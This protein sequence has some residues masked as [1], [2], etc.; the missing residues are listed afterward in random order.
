MIQKF[1]ISAALATVVG[2]ASSASAGVLWTTWTSGTV[3][4]AS[5]SA[6]GVMGG[7]GVSY[8]GEMECL[9]CYSSGWSPASTWANNP[10]P[11]YSPG[12]DSGIQLWGGDP[13]VTDTIT[14]SAPVLNPVMAIVSLGSPSIPASFVF[15]EGE[16]FILVGGGPSSQWGGQ[17]LTR[18]GQ[19]VW[20]VEGNGLVQFL[21]TYSSITWTNPQQEFY[22]AATVGEAPEPSTWAMM[23]L[24]F[25]GLA[26]A[27][28]LRSAKARAAIG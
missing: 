19:T 11:S 13:E 17:A 3:D 18:D 7:V 23:G 8:S 22:F 10:P 24:G 16:N 15:A 6:T 27:G 12:S 20:G 21:G 26:C 28:F 1:L 5:G 9:N 4:A 2:F 14:F 25:A